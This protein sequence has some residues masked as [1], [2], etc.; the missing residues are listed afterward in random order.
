MGFH[1]FRYLFFFLAFWARAAA[2]ANSTPS[3]TDSEVGGSDLTQN[4]TDEELE[5]VV[6]IMSLAG[7]S[8][9]Q[10]AERL[11]VILL[12]QFLHLHGLEG[13]LEELRAMGDPAQFQ[14]MMGEFGIEVEKALRRLSPEELGNLRTADGRLKLLR[15]VY[16][17]LSTNPRFIP[18]VQNYVQS[19]QEKRNFDTE[20]RAAFAKQLEEKAKNI[21]QLLD[22]EERA[23]GDQ[24]ASSWLQTITALEKSAFTQQ[25]TRTD[26]GVLFTQ[27]FQLDATV[28]VSIF[29]SLDALIADRF[30]AD[31]IRGLNAQGFEGIFGFP[32]PAAFTV[33]G[34]FNERSFAAFLQ[35]C[36]EYVRIRRARLAEHY[37]ADAI[38]QN[39][40][41]AINLEKLNDTR[42]TISTYASRGGVETV[43]AARSSNK[44]RADELRDE[45]F[46]SDINALYEEI[47]TKRR[48]S[49]LT[50][51]RQMQA[52]EQELLRQNFERENQ[53]L[54]E[55][56]HQGQYIENEANK[57]QS[58]QMAAS[59]LQKGLQSSVSAAGEA[60]NWVKRQ[61]GAAALNALTGGATAVLPIPD[62]LKDAAG[63]AVF[64]GIGG[65]I[66]GV[67]VFL[68]NLSNIISFFEQGVAF[69][70]HLL[71]GL[72][73]AGSAGVSAGANAGFA[74]GAAMGGRTAP[75]VNPA[76]TPAPSATV[77]SKVASTA[78]RFLAS[79]S[80]AVPWTF[81]IMTTGALVL[82]SPI[83][84]AFLP[85]LPTISGNQV[86]PYVSIEKV[87][88]PLNKGGSLPNP[89]KGNP[90]TLTYSIKI[91][92][93]KGYA[94]KITGITDTYTVQVNDKGQ[95][96][97]DNNLTGTPPTPA[98]PDLA[99]NNTIPP[100]LNPEQ[101]I[102]LKP[103]SAP[104]DVNYS[105]TSV[106]NTVVLKFT[107]SKVGQG[108]QSTTYSSSQTTATTATPTGGQLTAQT[109]AIVCFGDCPQSAKNGC[110]PTSG[111]I[112]QL[113]YGPQDHKGYGED[114]YDIGATAGTPIYAPYSGQACAANMG[115]GYGQYIQLYV[116]E[117][118]IPG[119]VGSGVLTFGHL[120]EF[121]SQFDPGTVASCSFS[122]FN[123]KM[124]QVKAGDLIGKVGSTGNSTGPHLH[125][126]L[127]PEGNSARR[128]VDIVPDGA[129]T[130]MGT[131]VRSCYDDGTR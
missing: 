33:N 63:T 38:D 7:V 17:K 5:S 10:E 79:S 21:D 15:L 96:R 34:V 8:Y 56:E 123:T 11:R 122:N 37:K 55:Y 73:S 99:K 30:S 91:T 105:D 125:Y 88:S 49:F 31:Q 93:K 32:A 62:E 60:A 112:T 75:L 66:G 111:I 70:G 103:Y 18:L 39:A 102:T 110:W 77:A 44:K 47:E 28:Q 40:E 78:G 4:K 85:P 48:N 53:L 94:L 9:A 82:S 68:S 35:V 131:P 1:S 45:V 128:L 20:A 71:G 14:E 130:Q 114:A 59:P 42:Q 113:P 116:P 126:Q 61:V 101:S 118:E 58:G 115:D 46:G 69:V 27:R 87:V 43:V 121:G 98:D 86:S 83:A 124:V 72:T 74:R 29:L 19:Y 89:T 106:T 107:A 81:G 84:G 109:S 25:A 50:I 92:A 23:K 120:Q 129:N 57:Y 76:T 51:L 80:A 117:L 90:T 16:A 65:M 64:L 22:Q 104:F 2:G 13:S 41:G 67:L 26:F 97:K 12:P 3:Q 127:G 6:E 119:Q 95:A 24:D 100:V 36:A 52:D 108:G 54:S